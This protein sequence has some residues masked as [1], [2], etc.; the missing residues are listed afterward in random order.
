VISGSYHGRIH[1]FAGDGKGGFK[2]AV[3]L[4]DKKGVPL[5]PG[6]S[7]V[8]S[9]TDWEGDGDLDLVV[10]CCSGW[11]YWIPNGSGG[12]SLEFGWRIALKVEGRPIRAPGRNSGPVVA[13]WDG[14]G[15]HDLLLGC[16]NGEVLFYRNTA[17]E[18][19]PV[20]AAP[21]PILPASSRYLH[22]KKG[23]S[24]C[25][26]DTK[27]AVADWNGDGRLD[28]LVGDLYRIP[29]EGRRKGE[30]HGN[31]WVLLRRE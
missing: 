11:V 14:D 22:G 19:V 4:T 28:L 5:R 1:L 6:T 27:L 24:P 9:V 29:V 21:V 31:V 2:K 12:K 30:G 8:V 10:G 15:R 13:D 17:K 3:K 26:F 23:E 18:G 7:T 16:G 20:L 25:G